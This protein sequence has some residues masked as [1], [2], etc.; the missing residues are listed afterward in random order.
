MSSKLK[1]FKESTASLGRDLATELA[2]EFYRE[3]RVLH[4]LVLL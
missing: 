3:D 4:T 2:L 1:Q